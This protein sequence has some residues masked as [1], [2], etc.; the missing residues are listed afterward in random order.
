[1]ATATAATAAA[2]APLLQ[3]SLGT[4]PVARGEVEGLGALVRV[5]LLLS[6][7]APPLS[8]PEGRAVGGRGRGAAVERGGARRPGGEEELV[9]GGGEGRRGGPLSGVGA[10]TDDGA[11]VILAL[12]Q[13]PQQLRLVV[14]GRH[15]E[16]GVEA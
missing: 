16:G 13:R 11:S 6:L 2:A 9:L 15:T 10:E 3:W 12:S 14:E 5:L 7:G 4:L 8:G 1:M